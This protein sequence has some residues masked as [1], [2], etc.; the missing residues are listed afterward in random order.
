MN[1]SWLEQQQ[2]PDLLQRLAATFAIPGTI[3]GAMLQ[4]QL[5]I[6][7]MAHITITHL[8]FKSMLALELP[9][10]IEACAFSWC[11]PSAKLIRNLL[12][13]SLWMTLVIIHGISLLFGHGLSH[14]GM[15][16]LSVPWSS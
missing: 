8:A 13:V 7:G 9:S 15:N 5:T 14:S 1:R 11:L 3:R 2:D 6:F 12:L 16:C 4:Y 10:F